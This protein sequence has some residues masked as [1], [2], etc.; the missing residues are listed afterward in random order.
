MPRAVITVPFRP[1]L[2]F[3]VQFPKLSGGS[4]QVHSAP[5]QAPAHT[6]PGSLSLAGGLLVSFPAFVFVQLVIIIQDCRVLSSN[7]RD[8]TAGTSMAVCPSPGVVCLQSYKREH[9]LDLT[10]RSVY[11]EICNR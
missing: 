11:I 8:F 3:R 9:W 2:R 1:D 7:C 10:A 4:S 5:A 6:L